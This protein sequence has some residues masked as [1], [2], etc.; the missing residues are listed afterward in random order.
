MVQSC[1]ETLLDPGD[2]HKGMQKGIYPI[3]ICYNGFDHY[4]PTRPISQAAWHKWKLSHELAPILSAGLL[5]IEELQRDQLEPQLLDAVNEVEACILKNWGKFNAK[6]VSA[7]HSIVQ[8][9][10]RRGPV[11]SMASSE[12]DVPLPDAQP[13]SSSQ[14]GPA[15]PATETVSAEPPTKAGRKRYICD[16]CG[17][18]K[19][20]KPALVGHLWAVHK[21]G[22]PIVCNLAPC[23]DNSFST[24][25]ALKTHIKNIHQ[26]GWRY[27]CIECEAS[28]DKWG[29]DSRAEYTTHKV[30][31]HGYKIRNKE[32]KKVR[33][34]KCRK[35][36]KKFDG[37]SLLAKHKGRGC[38]KKKKVQCKDCLKFYISER[39][40]RLHRD[41][42]HTPGAKTWVCHL[43]Q[44]V[45]N[46]LAASLNHS[47]WHRGINILARARAIRLRKVRTAG[48]AASSQEIA[49]K[50]PHL[51][52]KRKTVPPQP[53]APRASRDPTKS[54]P[55]KLIP[56]RSPRKRAGKK[57]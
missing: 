32:T 33:V 20:R 21:M 43:C 27:L 39:N 23:V 36:Y 29:T 1:H 57:K 5:V 55:P 12:P 16:V 45:C 10:P 22:D 17:V 47:M 9:A 25:A 3:V 2:Y 46:S 41:Q 14:P 49:K 52:K 54:A 56:R 51:T 24:N 50:L 38:L 37:P 6:V 15:T 35:C 53:R 34:Y 11:F 42:H 48:M 31:K 28:G 13:S 44:K 18:S 7:H 19:S 4:V 40:L 26:K 8:K 30:R